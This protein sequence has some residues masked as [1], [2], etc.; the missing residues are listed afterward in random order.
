MTAAV[1]ELSKAA[2]SSSLTPKG[3]LGRGLAAYFDNSSL[4]SSRTVSRA[5]IRDCSIEEG[6][7]TLKK[8]QV[9][10]IFFHL[11]L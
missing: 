8:S 5:E 4:D 2:F 1:R 11:N 6:G 10:H 3:H 7:V 9:R